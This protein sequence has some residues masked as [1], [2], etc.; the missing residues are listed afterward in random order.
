MNGM[1]TDSDFSTTP[2]PTRAILLISVGLLIVSL[3][4]RLMS[5]VEAV[6]RG[7]LAGVIGI[8]RAVRFVL[9]ATV[10]GLGQGMRV[11]SRY[12]TAAACVV[13]TPVVGGLAV[14]AYAAIG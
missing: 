6:G 12:R 9:G 2:T 14:T 5:A 13:A 10:H 7:L 4:L 11:V 8:G 1:S 3:V